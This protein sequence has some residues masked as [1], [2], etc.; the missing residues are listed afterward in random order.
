M[1]MVS[2][3]CITYNHEKYLTKTFESMLAQK[4]N[5]EY[6]IIVH[7][8]ASTDLSQKIIKEYKEKYP[9]I[10][11]TI[12]QK[13]NQYSKGINFISKYIFPK[14]RG[15]YIAICE[16]DDYW[17][18]E[19][20]LQKQFDLMEN[21]KNCSLCIHAGLKIDAKTNNVLEEIRLAS[22]DKYFSF[23]D[24]INGLGSKA[25]TNSF[26]YRASYVKNI[27]DYKDKLPKTSVGD[28][29]LA[30][31]LSLYG[32]I[33]YIDEFMSVYRYGVDGSWTTRMN[34][35][36]TS[37][38]EFLRK[39]INMLTVLKTI[40]PNHYKPFVDEKILDEQIKKKI[41]CG[42][43]DILTNKKCLTMLSTKSKLKLVINYILKKINVS[44]KNK[45]KIY[46][47]IRQVRKFIK[48]DLKLS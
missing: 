31:I 37:Y 29:I 33:Y 6:E 19:Q 40:I 5:F 28:Y 35:S 13:D 43:I 22:S 4:T 20:K 17:I 25:P 16:G 34:N 23:N 7:D 1:I 30:V 45:D 10:F 46:S 27:Q 2:I 18:D 39:N 8:D 48:N 12:L 42:E 47:K 41:L 11:V 21:N 3:I 24:A 26:F 44:N 9:K 36:V 15:K 14:I 38:I 32:D